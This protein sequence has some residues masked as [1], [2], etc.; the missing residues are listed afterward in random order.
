MPLALD[1]DDAIEIQLL[2][3]KK[4]GYPN[5]MAEDAVRPND[6]GV[7]WVDS[8]CRGIADD[9]RNG[10]LTGQERGRVISLMARAQE[11]PRPDPPGLQNKP[12]DRPS[13]N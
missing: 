2:L 12:V 5:Y 11:R 10:L 4:R 9:V 6:D 1:G 7:I 3:R 13:R 8:G